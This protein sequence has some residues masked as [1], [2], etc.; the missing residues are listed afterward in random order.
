[1]PFA[2]EIV[3]FYKKKKRHTHKH[4]NSS[5]LR[6]LTLTWLHSIKISFQF[7]VCLSYFSEHP[8]PIN[9]VRPLI[10]LQITHLPLCREFHFHVWSQI[11]THDFGWANE[12]SDMIYYLY[13]FGWILFFPWKIIYVDNGSRKF[14]SCAPIEVDFY[15]R[16]CVL[17]WKPTLILTI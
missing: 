3:G 15:F 2:P 1:M 8:N 5:E 7:G 4:H 14:G 13:V 12:N 10:S 17:C 11:P 6:A 16:F 9:Y